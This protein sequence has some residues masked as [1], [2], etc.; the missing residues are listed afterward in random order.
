MAAEVTFV[1]RDMIKAHIRGELGPEDASTV[2]AV[3]KQDCRVR[4]VANEFKKQKD[5]SNGSASTSTNE[6][7]DENADRHFSQAETQR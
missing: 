4:N 6:G 3:L 2:E 7:S 1:T 5:A